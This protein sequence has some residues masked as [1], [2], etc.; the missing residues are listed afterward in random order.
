MEEIIVFYGK[1]VDLTVSEGLGK[2]RRESLAGRELLRQGLD[3]LYHISLP[4]GEEG[5][6]LLD[7]MLCRAKNGKPRLQKY[8]EIH[9]N[10]SHSGEYVVCAMGGMPVGIDIQVRSPIRNARLLKRTMN[11]GQQEAVKNAEDSE[12]KFA[13]LWAQKE[14]Y[15]KWTGEG[16]TVDLSGLSMKDAWMEKLNL[17]EGYAGWVCAA[18]PFRLLKYEKFL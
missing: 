16:I 1:T 8:P 17:R 3:Q 14:A 2:G 11:T 15:L 4:K 5:F 18:K 13:E 10:I 7:E 12:M 6:A 9:F